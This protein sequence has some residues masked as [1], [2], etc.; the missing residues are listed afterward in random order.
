[1]ILVRD[2]DGWSLWARQQLVQGLNDPTLYPVFYGFSA[3]TGLGAPQGPYPKFRLPVFRYA[4]G[5]RTVITIPPS[6]IRRT[7]Y[8][9]LLPYHGAQAARLQLGAEAST[10]R[11]LGTLEQPS[12]KI[13]LSLKPDT[14]PLDL[15]L[16]PLPQPQLAAMVPE[17]LPIRVARLQVLPEESRPD[18]P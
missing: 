18:G 16:M 3:T 8:L 13:A 17:P 1:M 10:L 6:P 9:E 11:Q 2:W 5:Q 12:P 14:Q 4:E 7:L 15:V